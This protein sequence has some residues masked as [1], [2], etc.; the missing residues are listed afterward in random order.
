MTFRLTVSFTRLP[1]Y[2][3]PYWELIETC[4]GPQLTRQWD[5]FWPRYKD[6]SA[7]V[8][9]TSV[10]SR[11]VAP[12]DYGKVYYLTIQESLVE[13]GHSQRRPGLHVDSPGEVK[14]KASASSPSSE[15]LSKGN[16]SSHMWKGHHWGQG[17]AHYVD[18]G[19]SGDSDDW[20]EENDNYFV[21][22]G[23]IFIASSVANSCK[24]WNCEVAPEAVKRYKVRPW[25]D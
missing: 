7:H 17:N 13:A 21:V 2:V 10:L 20:A 24:A 6:K 4:I 8:W 22:Y 1:E 16:G 11:D 12:S 9:V 25:G 3:R 5:N 14:I 23:G 19:D 15:G 18:V